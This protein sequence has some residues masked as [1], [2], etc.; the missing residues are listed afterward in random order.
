MLEQ[1]PLGQQ[2]RAFLGDPLQRFRVGFLQGDEILLLVGDQLG[3]QGVV[4]ERNADFL[5]SDLVEPYRAML[6]E[7]H[8][9]GQQGGDDHGDQ[10]VGQPG[11]IAP[12]GVH[13]GEGEHGHA[14]GRPMGM[15]HGRPDGVGHE[16]DVMLAGFGRDPEDLA[17]L[18]GGDDDGGGVDETQ[19]HGVRQEIQQHAQAEHAHGQLEQPD[20]QGQ[21]QRVADEGLAAGGRQ[22]FQGRRRHQRNH[23]HGPGR[24]LA[25][26]TEKSGHHGRHQGCIQPVVGRQASQLRISHGLGDQD[27]RH[28]H[29]GNGVRPQYFPVFQFR[30]PVGQREGIGDLSQGPS[31]HLDG[32]VPA[33]LEF[34]HP[35]RMLRQ[36]HRRV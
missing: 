16:L 19:H 3:L 17:E 32:H 33:W 5:V 22:R 9:P 35:S 21:Q 26:G 20:H 2:L 7:P 12:D 31:R 28:R 1:L 24:Q 29:P 11:V 27:Q 18:R 8:Q 15:L 14:Q 23:R 34:T 4:H 6:L 30:Q 25:G 10:H 13:G 36:V